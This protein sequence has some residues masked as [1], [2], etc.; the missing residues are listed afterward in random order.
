MINTNIEWSFIYLS[1][2]LDIKVTDR[3]CNEIHKL[4]S[5]SL[6][7]Y[8]TKS[9]YATY[10]KSLSLLTKSFPF[11]GC[12]KTTISPRAGA[13]PKSRFFIGQIENGQ[14]YLE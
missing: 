5:S 6:R 3:K 1:C 14:E 13:V 12:R 8:L 11:I 10:I 4:L 7:K 9:Q 2:A